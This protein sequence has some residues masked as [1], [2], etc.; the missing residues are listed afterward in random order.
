MRRP[1]LLSTLQRTESTWLRSCSRPSTYLD[2]TSQY[3]WDTPGPCVSGSRGCCYMKC[4][5]VS[6]GAGA[7]G[8]LDVSAGGTED[9]DRHRHRQRRRSDTRHTCGQTHVTLNYTCW[10]PEPVCSLIGWCDCLS[11][12]E[13][14]VI[15]SCIKHIPIAGRDITFFIQQLLRDR[16]VGIPPEQS[17]ET[18]KAVKVPESSSSTPP[19]LCS[20]SASLFI[21]DSSCVFLYIFVLQY[22]RFLCVFC[23]YLCVYLCV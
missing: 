13:G 9:S 16:E 14:Y 12:A 20:S 17:L 1:S 8:V 2:S 23:V 5:C 10:W 21:Y 7:G 3:R 6:G 4:L 11:Q 18:A 15:G 19:L 22:F